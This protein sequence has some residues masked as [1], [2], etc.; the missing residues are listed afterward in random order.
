MQISIYDHSSFHIVPQQLLFAPINRAAGIFVRLFHCE[1][2]KLL[3]FSIFYI[4]TSFKLNFYELYANP[5]KNDTR[6]GKKCMLK[7]MFKYSSSRKHS[8]E[9]KIIYPQLLQL[10]QSLYY[11]FCF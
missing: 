8:D 10:S 7:K 9:M 1:R 11:F 4:F 5:K 6:Y 2:Q 3:Q